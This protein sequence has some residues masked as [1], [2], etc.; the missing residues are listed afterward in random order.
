M[1]EISSKHELYGVIQTNSNVNGNIASNGTV[2]ASLIAQK[3]PK[4]DAF[5]YSDFTPEQLEA[6]KGPA[7]P[8]GEKGADG[9]GISILGS[10]DTLEELNSAH[11]TGN[12][13]DGYMV[14][15]NLYVWN[16]TNKT[17][18]D[19]GNIQGP[20][21][22]DGIDGKNGIDGK[23]GKAAT[24]AVGTTTTGEKANV[25]NS[26]TETNAILDFTIPK[27]K[28][29][30]SL[31]GTSLTTTEEPNTTYTPKEFELDGRSTQ[32]GTPTPDAPVEIVSVGYENLF[33][34]VLELGT[35]DA[36]GN[37]DTN[38]NCVRTTNYIEVEPSTRYYVFN[39]LG[40]QTGIQYYD[41]NKTFIRAVAM[42]NGIFTT[43]ANAKYIRWRS[44]V[45]NK[46]N[47]LEVK[48]QL[49]KGTTGHS[50]VPHGKYGVEVKTTNGTET[51]T[52]VFVLDKPLRSIP[53]GTKDI[54]YIKDNKLYVERKVGS[55]ILDGDTKG[56]CGPS[57]VAGINAI[58]VPID[59]IM[60]SNYGNGICSHFKKA[61]NKTANTVR[62]G[63]NDKQIWFYV[64]ENDFSTMVEFRT[65]LS[66]HNTEVIYELETPVT[67]ELGNVYINFVEGTNNVTNSADTNMR[68]EYYTTL[69][70]DLG[71][72]V[73]SEIPDTLYATGA[74]YAECFEWEDGNPDNEDRRSLFVSIVNGTRKIRK[75]MTGDDILGITS[76]D[77]SVVGNAAYKD[78][79]THSIVGM[80]GVIRVKDNGQCVVGDYVIPGDN[81]IAVPS[82]NDSGYKVTA[83]YDANL[84]EVLLA[85]DAEMI[86]RLKDDV[87]VIE[88]KI[89]NG[90]GDTLPVGTIVE[91]DG[92]EV[93]SGF[94]IVEEEE[95]E[96]AGEVYSTEERKIGTWINSKPIY[97][98]VVTL[99][100]GTDFTSN[101]TSVNH[102]IA[103]IDEIINFNVMSLDS[104]TGMY[105]PIP[106]AY[107]TTQS[108]SK[109][110][111]G[112]AVDKT[113]F[114]LEIGT[115]FYTD[116]TLK[117]NIIIEYTKTTN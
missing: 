115:T 15:T 76:I 44:S 99:T 70:G 53:D 109:Y 30:V 7:G 71:S 73:S 32:N 16:E 56:T 62:F 92:D 31:E 50:Y 52:T 51:N 5:T 14:G 89:E 104:K 96:D 77:A 102:N 43:P 106:W 39:N 13:G 107:Y 94:E 75:S 103:N 18:L 114:K 2:F 113:K 47:N 85:H 23:D 21:G 108:D 54:A 48:Y 4:G 55:I 64:N 117:F 82:T 36:T 66:T 116:S 37:N 95:E 111:G 83:R 42:T 101:N 22:K 79:T 38:S 61:T 45:G 46:E 88:D 112:I 69:K 10:Y 110:Y 93:P 60:P 35:F 27:G 24:I 58:S 6:L 67:E 40:Y 97:R 91:Y 11:P 59:D 33:D 98:K 105:R 20:K 34:G 41:E 9:T 72:G 80:V 100:K 28:I 12:V 3:G 78:D 74:D 49:E 68:M 81:G 29:S 26:G 17:W 65:W 25:V 90:V 63:A 86:S 8:Q 87:K 57:G 1:A 84:I 19:V